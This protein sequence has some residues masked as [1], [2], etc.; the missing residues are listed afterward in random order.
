MLPIYKMTKMTYNQTM[1]IRTKIVCLG[2]AAALASFAATPVARVISAQPV[3]VDGIIGPARNFAPL[4]IGN[5]VTT[6]SASA[7]IQ[8]AD[9]SVVT[10][11]PHSKVRIEGQPSSA[12]ARVVQGSA[13]Y[14]VA[15]TSST[16]LG[17][18]TG[19]PGL[20]APSGPTR[21]QPGAS[22]PR[23]APFTGSFN[24]GTPS[25]TGPQIDGPNGVTINLTSAVNPVTGAT[26]FVVSS[27]QETITLPSGG[28][29]V[30]T[31]TSG[32]LIGATVG[33]VATGTFT[34]TTPG[35]TAPLTPQQTST[36]VQT[37]LQQAINSGVASG[38]L[39]TGTK[40]PSPAPVSGT[41]F[42]PSGS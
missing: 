5:E 16:R 27:I 24:P 28:T 23:P 17:N 13:I 34:F 3:N 22:A 26:T 42:S 8:F 41:Q 31:I 36:A 33:G 39:P 32:T 10:L 15:K 6:D 2:V 9:G 29:A 20:R 21:P 7:V 19:Q 14:D 12:T 25:G 40:L 38:T 30:V 18:G 4:T 11:Q 35:S 37:G 1:Q